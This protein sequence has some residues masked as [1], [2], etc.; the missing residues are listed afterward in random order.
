MKVYLIIFF[1]TTIY[2]PPAQKLAK[3]FSFNNHEK[4]TFHQSDAILSQAEI[5]RKESE[6]RLHSKDPKQNTKTKH[7]LENVFAIL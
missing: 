1:C 4:D 6:L 5:F 7:I 3:Y 2:Q